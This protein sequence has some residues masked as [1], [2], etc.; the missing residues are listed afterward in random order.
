MTLPT[1]TWDQAAIIGAWSPAAF[2]AVGIKA[3][4]IRQ[5]AARNRIQPVGT[6]PNGCRL[7]LYDQVIRLADPELLV[8]P[9]NPCHTGRTSGSPMPNGSEAADA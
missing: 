7:Y 4:T 5:W 3:A 8:P 1:Y 9:D 2:A 6:G